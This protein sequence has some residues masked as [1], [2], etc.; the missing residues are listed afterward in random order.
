MGGAP[1]ASTLRVNSTILRLSPHQHRF[2][3]AKMMDPNIVKGPLGIVGV[4]N[5][6]HPAPQKTENPNSD[7]DLA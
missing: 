6:T 4:R 3:S 1:L 2:S 7:V 5:L